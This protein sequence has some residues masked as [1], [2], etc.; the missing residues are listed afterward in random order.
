LGILKTIIV[1]IVNPTI[2]LLR[3]ASRA[4]A[5]AGSR[6]HCYHGQTVSDWNAISKIAI[7][8][9]S[10]YHLA[11][12]AVSLGYLSSVIGTGYEWCSQALKFVPQAMKQCDSKRSITPLGCDGTRTEGLRIFS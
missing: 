7:R 6:L 4:A 8:P 12:A 1:E 5:R 9:E 3:R 11:E 10:I 2:D